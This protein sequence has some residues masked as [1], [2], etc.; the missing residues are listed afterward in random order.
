MPAQA[1]N[2]KQPVQ[3]GFNLTATQQEAY[4]TGNVV[5]WDAFSSCG[6]TSHFGGK[7]M[8]AYVTP[9]PAGKTRFHDLG[10]INPHEAGG[11]VL[12]MA[13]TPIRV[14]KVEGTPGG[15]MKVWVT[16]MEKF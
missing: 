1:A 10:S 5:M 12:A 14:D 4:Q 6:K 8:V 3:R 16:E 11:E 15:K 13:H 2:L 9:L 7:N